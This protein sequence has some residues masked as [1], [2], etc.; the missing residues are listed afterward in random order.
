MGELDGEVQHQPILARK[1]DVADLRPAQGREDGSPATG[2]E[3]P[4]EGVG[5]AVDQGSGDGD[6]A[7]QAPGCGGHVVGNE[8]GSRKQAGREKGGGGAAD[9]AGQS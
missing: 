1:L 6:G 5:G 3:V 2:V 9:R 7:P 4:G 8:G